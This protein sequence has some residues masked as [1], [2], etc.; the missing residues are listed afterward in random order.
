MK[1]TIFLF[2]ILWVLFNL[3]ACAAAKPSTCTNEEKTSSPNHFAD[4]SISHASTAFT[5]DDLLLPKDAQ[6]TA[7]G[8]A[9]AT[10]KRGTDIKPAPTDAVKLYLRIRS[11]DGQILNEGE[12][13]L[14][15][16]HSTPFFEEILP[17]M[18]IGETI[19]VW[20]DQHDIWEIE[21][22]SIDRA[23]TAPEDVAQPPQ[24][25]QSIA[26]FDGVLWRVVEEGNGA[27]FTENQALRI[28]ISRWD[29]QGS[30]LESTKAGRGMIF[31]LNDES[32]Q[33]D[34]LHHSLFLAQTPGT[35]LRIWIPKEV[36]HLSS[37]IVED[38]WLIETV[39]ALNPPQSLQHPEQAI[40]VADGAWIRF[41]TKH[42]TSTIKDGDSVH[43]DMTCWNRDSGQIIDATYFRGTPDIM[44]ITP[45]LGIYRDIML[46]TG[47]GD[48]LLT[49]IDAS[50]L[51]PSVGIPLTCR[52]H[53]LDVLESSPSNEATAGELAPSSPASKE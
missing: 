9:Y 40:A 4:D 52:I 15:L 29:R 5:A 8:Y 19:R 50:V 43:V 2:G 6:S 13:T 20:G 47:I 10:V 37:D 18:H 25:A 46:A 11:L 24:T 31:F 42:S 33:K 39:D 21:M 38:V 1:K 41:E 34:P 17:L 27:A 49:W 26:G 35:H 51:P 22:I 48:T 32:R 16:A 12:R 3:I 53:V 28:H 30:I 7:S 36:A 14:S 44:D 45:K 23:Y